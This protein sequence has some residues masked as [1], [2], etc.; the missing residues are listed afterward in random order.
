MH[1]LLRWCPRVL[2]RAEEPELV[3]LPKPRAPL[4]RSYSSAAHYL[5]ANAE[6][7]KL[8][9]RPPSPPPPTLTL[10]LTLTPASPEPDPNRHP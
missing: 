9:A 3:L 7:L 6:Y 10:T 2:L 4:P 1:T 8:E 5:G